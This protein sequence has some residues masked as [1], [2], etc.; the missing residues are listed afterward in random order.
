MIR[1]THKEFWIVLGITLLLSALFLIFSG[2]IDRIFYKWSGKR[3][4]ISKPGVAFLIASAV[5][6]ALAGLTILFYD[7]RFKDF[8]MHLPVF[9]YPAEAVF[10][11]KFYWSL[12]IFFLGFYG[13]AV[14]RSILEFGTKAGIVRSLI[15]LIP[16]FCIFWTTLATSFIVVVG[17]IILAVMSGMASDAGKGPRSSTTIKEEVGTFTG[18]KKTVQINYD[19][20]GNQKSKKYI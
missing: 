1:F 3:P 12:Q 15:L 9:R 19:S 20:Q 8:V 4:K 14:Y 16:A 13:W 2:M 7:L 18:E 17:A 10:V 5:F 6:G 11:V